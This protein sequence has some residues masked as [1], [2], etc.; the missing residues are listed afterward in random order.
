MEEIQ[1]GGPV[2]LTPEQMAFV[3]NSIHCHFIKKLVMRFFCVLLHLFSK[4][5]HRVYFLSS[6]IKLLFSLK[7]SLFPELGMFLLKKVP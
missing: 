3:T 7:S 2:C 1:F 5:I 6:Q 4:H